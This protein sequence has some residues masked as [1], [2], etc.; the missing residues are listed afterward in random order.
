[1]AIE[2]TWLGHGCWSIHIQ[3]SQG[4]FRLL[5]DPFLDESPAAPVSS[6]EVAADFILVSH[7]HFDHIADCVKI[8][9]RTDAIVISNYEIC[10]WLGQQG[11][12]RTHPHNLGGGSE[13]PFGRVELTIAHHSS[14]LPDG[15]YGGNPSGFLLEIEG[16]H[17]Y[18]ACDTALFSDMKLIGERGIDFAVLP[19]GDQFTMGPTDSLRAIR[20]IEPTQVAPAHYN[21]WPPIQ[22]NAQAWAQRVRAETKAEPCVVLPGG[23]IEIPR[24][25]RSMSKL[26]HSP[27]FLTGL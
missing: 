16:Q 4:E 2:L 18:F 23:R 19:I 11:V 17:L 6:D 21:T 12:K 1:M 9:K 8:A 26:G 15:A 14:A 24:S 5:L 25:A 3:S 22:Q 20:M 7:G 10:E 27:E 13:Q